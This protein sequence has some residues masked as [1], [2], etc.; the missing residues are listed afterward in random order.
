MKDQET[1]DQETL[2]AQEAQE[3]QEAQETLEA[4]DNSAQENESS[5][6]ELSKKINSLF[7]SKAS[8]EEPKEEPKEE[9]KDQEPEEDEDD[10]TPEA[11][12]IKG[13][14]T[15]L[16]RLGES[17]KT[18]AQENE[19]LKKQL[20]ELSTANKQY[21]E[22]KAEEER[23][24]TRSAIM[25]KLELEEDE[26]KK[27]ERYLAKNLTDKQDAALALSIEEGRYGLIREYL[28]EYIENN[29]SRNAPRKRTPSS[30]GGGVKPYESREE[31]LQALNDWHKATQQ[32]RTEAAQYIDRR[33][34]ATSDRKK[35]EWGFGKI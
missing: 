14:R 13:L 30:Q 2:E 4:Q 26:F 19:E 11:K 27:F 32:G 33:L 12:R 21:E 10:L 25:E 35:Q 24:K 9:S 8:K 23:Q 20:E 6:D 31:V 3:D 29:T 17:N 16:S 5:E 15:E 7:R 1:Q 22:T 34:S 28:D 18:L